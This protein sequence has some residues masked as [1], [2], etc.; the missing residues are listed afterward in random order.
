CA[1]LLVVRLEERGRSNPISGGLRRLTRSRLEASSIVNAPVTRVAGN[2]RVRKH[3]TSANYLGHIRRASGFDRIWGKV[4]TG[5][6]VRNN[7]LLHP[8][9]KSAKQVGHDWSDSRVAVV[10]TGEEV[11][12]RDLPCPV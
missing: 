6:P 5:Q 7:P 4:I 12:Q 9:H 10:S 2:L 11:Q 8:P 3:R 1:P